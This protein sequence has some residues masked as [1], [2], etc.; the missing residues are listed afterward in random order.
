VIDEV[1][2][3]TD[4]AARGNP[5]PAAA[6]FR[7][8]DPVGGLLFEHEE[9]LG[10]R[11]NNQAEYEALIRGLEACHVYTSRRVR[12]GSDSSLLVNQMNRVWRVKNPDLRELQARALE[13]AAAFGEVRYDH[14]PRTHPEIVTV[15]QALRQLLDLEARGGSG[16]QARTRR[17]S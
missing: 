15:D 7:I 17:S 5:G 6:G 11:T 12:V 10:T 16:R 4:G 13:A 14:Y 3:Y 1:W 8:L 9:S 2:L